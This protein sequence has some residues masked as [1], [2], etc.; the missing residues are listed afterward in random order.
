MLFA[1]FM[2]VAMISFFVKWPSHEN[3]LGTVGYHLSALLVQNTF[4]IAS[5][6]FS[7]LLFLFGLHLWKVNPLPLKRTS[8]VTLFWMV[9]LSTVLGYNG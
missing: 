6:G 8:W 9:W 4:G 2:A 3:V 5:F 7:F 1:V